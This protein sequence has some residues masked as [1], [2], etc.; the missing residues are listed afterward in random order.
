LFEIEGSTVETIVIGR[1]LAFR[2]AFADAVVRFKP[3]AVKILR[4]YLRICTPYAIKM[5]VNSYSRAHLTGAVTIQDLETARLRESLLTAQ[6]GDA[7]APIPAPPVP[8]R[9]L[10]P[11][12][13]NA[14]ERALLPRDIAEFQRAVCVPETGDLGALGSETRLAIQ[15]ILDAHDQVLTDRTG[16][17]LRRRLRA[18]VTC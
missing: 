1:R 8:P 18:G 2:E 5:S 10:S 14:Y 7:S 6:I 16:V 9:I 3:D 4:D 11:T 17:L 15:S 12:R 13:F